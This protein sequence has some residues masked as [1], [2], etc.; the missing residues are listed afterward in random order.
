LRAWVGAANAAKVQLTAPPQNQATG[1]G[2]KPGEEAGDE[3]SQENPSR[4]HAARVG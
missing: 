4:N 3:G 1:A 2:D